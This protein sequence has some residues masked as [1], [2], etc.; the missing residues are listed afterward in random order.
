MIM[1]IGEIALVAAMKNPIDRVLMMA[2][3]DLL[4]DP[5]DRATMMTGEGVA[6]IVQTD[7]MIMTNQ[8]LATN[9]GTRD[10]EDVAEEEEA[11]EEVGETVVEEV[12]V[13]ETAA[14][15][16]DATEGKVIDSQV[17]LQRRRRKQLT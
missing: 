3:E 13:E 4:Q 2:G 17:K 16:E 15:I 6:V 12:G 14:M 7:G 9:L 11:D 10:A 5:K 8:L 1:M